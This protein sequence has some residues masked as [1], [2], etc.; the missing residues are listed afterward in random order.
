ML[1]EADCLLNPGATLARCRRMRPDGGV[2][3]IGVLHLDHDR[4]AYRAQPHGGEIDTAW[5][6]TIQAARDALYELVVEELY[7][8]QASLRNKLRRV[9]EDLALLDALGEGE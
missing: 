5:H 8:R 9:R 7:E 2:L 1:S 3:E 6:P 4:R